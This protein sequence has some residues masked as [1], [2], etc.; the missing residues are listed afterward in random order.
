MSFRNIL[1]QTVDHS[2][3]VCGG[4]GCYITHRNYVYMAE[5]GGPGIATDKTNVDRGQRNSYS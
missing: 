1:P 3:C 4:M 5:T 2:R